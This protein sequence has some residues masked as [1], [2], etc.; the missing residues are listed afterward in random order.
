M[1]A[2]GRSSR[3]RAHAR[4]P[5]ATGSTRGCATCTISGT[6]SPA[7]GATSP[8]RPR[9]LAFTYAQT[10]NRGI[11]AIVLAAAVAKGP[12]GL[13]LSWPRYLWRAW[14]RGRRARLLPA[15]HWEALLPLPLDEV[16][17]RLR[18]SPARSGAPGRHPGR[19][20]DDALQLA[21]V[22]DVSF[23]TRPTSPATAARSRGPLSRGADR[24]RRARVGRQRRRRRLRDG[25]RAPGAR[26][27]PERTR[28]RGADARVGRPRR[29]RVAI[30]GQGPAPAAA[31]IEAMRARGV[32][33]IP[34]DGL[35]AATDARRARRLVPAA[36]ALRHA[37][38]RRRARARA[39]ARRARLPD[40]PVPAPDPALLSSRASAT[41]GRAARRSTCRCA[42]T[43][44]A[45]RTRRSR[46]SSTR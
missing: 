26:A 27:A 38:P 6:C 32:A 35:L 41:S 11:G 21:P 13:D 30:S 9:N 14:R 16:R 3:A 5:S 46:A 42:R 36:R 24:R 33:L 1:D 18:V 44:S 22:G 37:P 7:T 4:S 29:A 17:R 12:K 10:R 15:A 25:L 43:A 2:Q 39:R 28:R 40:V 23:T 20:S 34:P 8:A 31:T 45:R 19:A